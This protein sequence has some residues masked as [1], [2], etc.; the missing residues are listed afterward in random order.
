M[1]NV[2]VWDLTT[3]VLILSLLISSVYL[4]GSF[5]SKHMVSECLYPHLMHKSVDS[6][7]SP[8]YGIFSVLLDISSVFLPM[9]TGQS[10]LI[11]SKFELSWLI[12]FGDFNYIHIIE[13]IDYS[14][15]GCSF[16]DFEPLTLSL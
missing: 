3:R 12:L 15:D 7:I 16:P 4:T 14:D 10:V 13:N 8:K 5:C 9:Q 2:A 11:L 6:I 1:L